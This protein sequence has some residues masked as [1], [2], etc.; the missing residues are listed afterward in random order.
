MRLSPLKQQEIIGKD[1]HRLIV[2]EQYHTAFYKGFREFEKSGE[3]AAIG[4]TLELAGIRKGGEE[5]PVELSLSSVKPN[6][7]WN[8]IGVIRDISVRKHAEDKMKDSHREYQ[9]LAE[10]FEES[11]RL[12]EL[13]LDIITHD[14]KNPIG[15]ILNATEILL[16]DVSGNE[17]LDI[18]QD[19]STTLLDVMEN[20]TV[21]A[22][23][24]IGDKIETMDLDLVKI[25]RKLFKEFASQLT[26]AQMKLELNLPTTMFIRANPIIAEIPKNYI[27]NAIKYAGSGRRIIVEVKAADHKITLEGMYFSWRCR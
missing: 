21:L 10:Q 14:L 9:L 1:L 6:G 26:Q 25:I 24:G 2:P 7:K 4:N 8:A 11:N 18:I 3:G 20:I 19:S 16:E 12:K 17:L 13:L 27:S 5:F 23:V 22:Q 15:N